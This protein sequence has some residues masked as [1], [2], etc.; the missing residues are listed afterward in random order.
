MQCHHDNEFHWFKAQHDVAIEAVKNNFN[1]G[2]KYFDHIS[3]ILENPCKFCYLLAALIQAGLDIDAVNRV[4]DFCIAASRTVVA[5]ASSDTDEF[6]NKLIYALTNAKLLSPLIARLGCSF[7]EANSWKNSLSAKKYN[8]FI[9]YTYRIQELAN[10]TIYWSA[11]S[12]EVRN[13]RWLNTKNEIKQIHNI[14]IQEAIKHPS[15]NNLRENLAL[16]WQSYSNSDSTDYSGLIEE[17]EQA[18]LSALW[19]VNEALTRIEL[20]NATIEPR[21]VTRLP[22]FAHPTIQIEEIELTNPFLQRVVKKTL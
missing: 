18:Y 19:R 2:M 11:E 9:K 13:N 6:D 16:T 7:D 3:S 14:F 5:Q 22:F 12:S 4:V 1:D 15:L 10:F 21:S 17:N 8:E 20:K